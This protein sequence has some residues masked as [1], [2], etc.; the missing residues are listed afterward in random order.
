[1]PTTQHV[2]VLE[3]S[4]AEVHI[5]IDALE[6]RAEHVRTWGDQA[7]LWRTP[8]DRDRVLGPLDE[9]VRKLIQA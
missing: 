6:T 8:A 2:N 4:N 1:M 7:G 3:L 5:L 9:L